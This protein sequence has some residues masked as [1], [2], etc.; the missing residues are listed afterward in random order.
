MRPEQWQK[1]MKWMIALCSGVALLNLMFVNMPD[2]LM[3]KVHVVVYGFATGLSV[4][5]YKD[6]K[7]RAK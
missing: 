4:W 7:R 3:N 6:A 2:S 1:I 5:C